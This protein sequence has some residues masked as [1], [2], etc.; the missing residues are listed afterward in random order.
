MISLTNFFFHCKDHSFLTDST[1]VQHR[2]STYIQ[3]CSWPLH[4]VALV[5]L[6]ISVLILH[7]LKQL[8]FTV[9]LENSFSLFF[10]KCFFLLLLLFSHEFMS[11]DLLNIFQNQLIK[12]LLLF[13]HPV[14]SDFLGCH[15]LQHARVPCPSPSSGVHPIHVQ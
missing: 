13:S 12:L 3:A 2:W 14:M 7:F 4:L 10:F 6:S 8:E 1:F 15:G 11:F 9:S 5:N